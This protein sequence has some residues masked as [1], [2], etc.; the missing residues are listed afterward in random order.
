MPSTRQ[1]KRDVYE[2]SNLS[3][4]AQ[5]ELSFI[6]CCCLMIIGW[7]ALALQFSKTHATQGARTSE[8]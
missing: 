1:G 8:F 6:L 4:G 5:L 3:L 7:T 2:S